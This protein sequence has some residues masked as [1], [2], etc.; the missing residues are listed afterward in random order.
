MIEIDKVLDELG[1]ERPVFHS[2]ADFQHAL[3][4]IIHEKH[5]ELKVRLEK[6]VVVKEGKEIYPDILIFGDREYVVIEVKYK[7][8]RFND[9]IAGETFNLKNQAAQDIARYDFILDISRL[10]KVVELHPNGLGFAIF[11]TNESTFWRESIRDTVDKDF[12]IHEER[13]IK[14][15]LR[16]G[17]K[18][19]EGTR[20]GRKEPL[21]LKGK[22]RLSW[23]DYSL[24]GIFKYLLIKV[25]P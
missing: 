23:H 8:K 10:E 24:G 25:K 7:T 3:A 12:R 22:Y 6:R 2:E 16:W 14:G 18:A 1:M 4:W 20:A 9:S 21:K 5:P 11:L 19:S 15:E 17:E 13:I